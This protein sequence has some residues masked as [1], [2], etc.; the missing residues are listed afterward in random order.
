M[1]MKVSREYRQLTCCLCGGD[2]GRYGHNIAPL[3]HDGRYATAGRCCDTCN[4]TKVIPAR[5]EWLK[6]EEE[7]EEE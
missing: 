5:F 3:Y 6:E 1:S 2:A 4:A 7:G